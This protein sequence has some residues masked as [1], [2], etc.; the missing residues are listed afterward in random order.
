MSYPAD[1]GAVFD[2]IKALLGEEGL[3]FL[4]EAAQPAVMV[5]PERLL[6]LA[7]ALKD[8]PELAFESLQ[9]VAGTDHPDDEKLRS[10]ATVC[11]YAHGRMLTFHV[12]VPRDRPRLPSLAGVWPAADWHERESWDLLGIV[13]EGHPDLRRIMLPDDW[14]GHPLRKDFEEKSEYN[15]IPTQRERE[16]L[17]WQK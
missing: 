5:T 1:H 13:Y 4:T 14:E 17:S 11:S 12:D 15:G 3:E 10:T 8:D 16:W 2:R 7:R 9:Q 6:D